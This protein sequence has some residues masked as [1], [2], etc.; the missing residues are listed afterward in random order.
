M[1]NRPDLDIYFM[2][3]AN[4]VKTR[5]T[6][7]RKQVGAVLVRNKQIIS[8]GYNG[9]PTGIKHCDKTGC[10]RQKLNIPSGQRHEL[11]VA[12]HAEA[13]AILQAAKNGLRT[14]GCILYITHSPCILC[15]KSIINAGIKEVIYHE[16]YNDQM[17]KHILLQANI[18]IR[19]I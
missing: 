6:C 1:D 18:K 10:L 12:S 16:E 13:N 11:C 2:N 4:V 14:D 3:I 8:T 5:S 15:T 17:S 19:R 9:A 7:L